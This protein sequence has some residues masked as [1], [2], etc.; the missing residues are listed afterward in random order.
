MDHA[1]LHPDPIWN[2]EALGYFK[3]HHPNK[4]SNKITS[5]MG[6]VPD[7]KNTYEKQHNI[8]IEKYL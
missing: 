8:N 3:E 1:K 7:P 6:P 4:K 5:D 2:D